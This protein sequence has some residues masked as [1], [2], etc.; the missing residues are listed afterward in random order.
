M[1]A[2]DFDKY[3]GNFSD[4]D[5]IETYKY[6]H[7]KNLCNEK[8]LKNTEESSAAYDE[9]FGKIKNEDLFDD[10]PCVVDYVNKMAGKK[11]YMDKRKINL[12][13]AASDNWGQ[14]VSLEH[15]FSVEEM[16][17]MPVMGEVQNEPDKYELCGT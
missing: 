6:I 14:P 16:L 2:K 9:I 5:L 15:D 3:I 7:S 8:K 12:V 17:D 1:L 11:R 10:I 13:N 4:A